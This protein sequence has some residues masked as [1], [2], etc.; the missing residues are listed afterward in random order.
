M[1]IRNKFEAL[2]YK[3]QRDSKYSN[4][5]SNPSNKIRSIRMHI[6]SSN[7]SNAN[8][9]YSYKIWN[10][11]MQILSIPKGFEAF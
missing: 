9:K 1:K 6:Q 8:S 4:G 10:I 3:F 5:N 7:H 2:V 11:R